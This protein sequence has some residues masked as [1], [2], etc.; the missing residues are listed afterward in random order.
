MPKNQE[1][2]IANCNGTC[3]IIELKEDKMIGADKCG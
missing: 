2:Q 3:K 1:A